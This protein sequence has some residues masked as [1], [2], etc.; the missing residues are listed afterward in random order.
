MIARVSASIDFRAASTS[1]TTRSASVAPCHAAATMARSSRFF[2]AKMPG[3]SM[4]TIWLSPSVAMPSTRVR[5][6]WTRGETID[7]FCPMMLFSRVDLPAFG[8][9]TSA[10]NPQRGCSGT[11][12]GTGSGAASCAGAGLL[13]GNLIVVRSGSLVT[14]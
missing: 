3:V 11:Y 6:V 10:T 1:S 5:V 2:G 9:P 14:H 4:K 13:F 7:T 8:A 12:I